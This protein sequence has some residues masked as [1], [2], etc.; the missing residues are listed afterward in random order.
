MNEQTKGELPPADTSHTH[1][2]QK[3]EA[4]VIGVAAMRADRF[5]GTG[6]GLPQAAIPPQSPS[7]LLMPPSIPGRTKR[8]HSPTVV[9]VLL[10]LALLLLGGGSVGVYG[11]L[12]GNWPP[13]NAAP[14]QSSTSAQANATSMRWHAQNAGTVQSFAGVAWSGSQFVAVGYSGAI[15]TSPDGRTWITQHAATAQGLLGIAWS[16]SQF[17]AVGGAGT[18]LTSS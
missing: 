17:V 18:I 16:G 4:G 11:A 14:W 2:V 12:T 5:D 10:L 6:D 1:Q 3:E 8:W 13:W 9:V 7:T 15:L